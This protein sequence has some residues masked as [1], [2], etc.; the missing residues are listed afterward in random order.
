MGAENRHRSLGAK[1]SS[2]PAP[3]QMSSDPAPDLPDFDAAKVR[4]DMLVL[5][6]VIPQNIYDN[7]KENH[8]NQTRC[9]ISL[10]NFHN[11]M[12]IAELPCGHI[13]TLGE[14]TDWFNEPD[15]RDMFDRLCGKTCPVCREK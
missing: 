8:A 14:I 5:C 9:P 12:R 10:E 7:T 15:R 2:D 6:G 11:G 1:M 4:R 13:F 3:D